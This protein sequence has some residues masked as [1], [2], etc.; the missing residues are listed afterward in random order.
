MTFLRIFFLLCLCTL[1]ESCARTHLS[2]QSDFLSRKNFA[3]T[4]IDTPDP[5]QNYCFIGESIAVRWSVPAD[6]FTYNDLHLKIIVRFGDRTEAVNT[7][8]IERYRGCY[9]YE[10]AN[11]EYID[12]KGIR[13]YKIEII[14]NGTIL[15]CW[16]HQMWTEL[17]TID[18]K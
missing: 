15:D 6:Y 17:I 3:S 5:W 11:Q 18:T 1:L 12:K 16:T 4:H 2:V 9:V 13:A 10:L 7:I 8:P 14:G